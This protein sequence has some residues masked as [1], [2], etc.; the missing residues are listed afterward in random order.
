MQSIHLKNTKTSRVD[1]RLV[2]WE[3]N[4]ERS[5]EEIGIKSCGQGNILTLL[6]QSRKSQDFYRFP[7]LLER[8]YRYLNPQNTKYMH[9]HIHRERD[10]QNNS[11]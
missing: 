4:D 2:K 11:L 10:T 3:G 5:R 8:E 6:K 1:A 9:V 7:P